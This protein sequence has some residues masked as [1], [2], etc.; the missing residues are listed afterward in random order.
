MNKEKISPISLILISLFLAC[1]YQADL[2]T[3]SMRM[4]EDLL[5]VHY[6]QQQ[7]AI[8][9]EISPS[10]RFGPGLDLAGEGQTGILSPVNITIRMLGI[11]PGFTVV[12]IF[13][14]FLAF[15]GMGLLL[16]QRGLALKPCLIGM[17][18]YGASLFLLLKV[19]HWMNFQVL[20]FLPL[21][22]YGQERRDGKGA[23]LM[24][25]L[26]GF[27]LLAGAQ[28]FVW[29]A[30]LLLIINAWL[31][32]C[33][34][35]K[36]LGIAMVLGLCLA[37]PQLMATFE[38]FQMSDR[39]GGVD[40]F[41]HSFLPK[42]LSFIFMSHPLGAPAQGNYVGQ[43]P[44]WEFACFSGVVS[45]CLLKY[46]PRK[47]LAVMLLVVI[48]A[49][50]KAFPIPLISWLHELPPFNLFRAPPRY[51]LIFVFLLATAAA[52]GLEN[53][54]RPATVDNKKLNK[55]ALGIFVFLL[56]MTYFTASGAFHP[57][58]ESIWS[59]QVL[60]GLQAKIQNLDHGMEYYHRNFLSALGSM[61]G[62][63]TLLVVVGALT[64]VFLKKRRGEFVVMLLL[65]ETL[66]AAFSVRTV[67]DSEELK[68]SAIPAQVK[69]RI[70]LPPQ[71]AREAEVA[72]CKDNRE[73][74][75]RYLARRPFVV[76]QLLGGPQ[77]NALHHSPLHPKNIVRWKNHLLKNHQE[78]GA[79]L[80][81]DLFYQRTGINYVSEKNTEGLWKWRK[82]PAHLGQGK[83][84]FY[85]G[86]KKET[87]RDL[88][89]RMRLRS[90][91]H[92]LE[93][94]FASVTSP[95]KVLPF[96]ENNPIKLDGSLPAGYLRFPSFM[97]GWAVWVDGK[98][99]ELESVDFVASAVRIPA[100][101]IRIELVQKNPM[102]LW[103]VYLALTAWVLTLIVWIYLTKEDWKKLNQ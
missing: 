67:L 91:Q 78:E 44:F 8:D 65:F 1:V 88:Y 86:E 40:S 55:M 87:A 75:G 51:L 5:S 68:L 63:L 56:A 93:F 45:L 10:Y 57:L 23:I 31:Q 82:I 60:P 100:G 52:H 21:V 22:V 101:A 9:G 61:L 76:S 27:S 17:I 2:L 85:E 29:I 53:F 35:I 12:T 99:L 48:F 33:F 14:Q 96:T 49:M 24:G 32:N 58:Y 28:Q 6:P 70:L 103:T 66:V 89:Q 42:Y 69:G 41:D 92:S 74:L 59:S 25:L 50:G 38:Q 98:E 11:N 18:A 26:L 80:Y 47:Y 71:M 84:L 20:C 94:E 62:Q 43:G 90:V 37:S 34:E 81:R 30:F 3:G 73:W 54:R 95:I 83:I 102:S 4:G 7:S 77:Q 79:A 72:F 64:F 97:P 46:A 39:S 13:L 16:K 19:E 15:L 36:Y